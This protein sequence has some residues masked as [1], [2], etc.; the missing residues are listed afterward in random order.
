M[1]RTRLLVVLEITMEAGEVFLHPA[2]L[3]GRNVVVDFAVQDV[4]ALL[5]SVARKCQRLA[6]G[7]RTL[8]DS[9][10]V[11]LTLLARGVA[12]IAGWTRAS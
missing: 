5:Q 6:G 12:A 3:V 1:P 10:Y 4:D 11:C 9:L 8:E 7:R 2:C